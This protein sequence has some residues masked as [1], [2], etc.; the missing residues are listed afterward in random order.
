LNCKGLEVFLYSPVETLPI[1]QNAALRLV[2]VWNKSG[3]SSQWNLKKIRRETGG[4]EPSSGQKI[5]PATSTKM[6]GKW[7]GRGLSGNAYEA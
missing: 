2:V 7:R 5:L 6:A 4:H 3:M 1:L